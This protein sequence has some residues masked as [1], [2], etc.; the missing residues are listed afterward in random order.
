M[1]KI[2][3]LLCD[4]HTLIRKGI[5]ALLQ[6]QPDMNVVGEAAHGEEAVVRVNE[7]VPDI[8]IL[9]IGLPGIS[10]LEVTRQLQKS[11]PGVKV[12]LL[13]IHDREDYLFRG[14]QAGAYGYVLKGADVNDLLTAIRAV[15]RGEVFI[16]P[17]MTTK[18]VHDYLKRA[19]NGDETDSYSI[20]SGRE[21]EVILL[22]AEG[23]TSRQ[24]AD[25]LG[26][27]P[28]TIRT[29]RDRLM[30]KLNLH[31]KAELIRYALRNGFLGP[32]S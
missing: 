21:K 19:Q 25:Q 14:L 12:I 2:K 10:G 4:D 29:H 5:A 9:D 22:I 30:E 23:K 8:V 20:L 3:V 31:S 13:T 26:L 6:E 7:L 11:S 15:H 16:Y 18:L 32:D 17:S 27:S 24:I 28:H 1:D